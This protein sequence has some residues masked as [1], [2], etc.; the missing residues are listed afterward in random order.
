[1]EEY[2]YYP[3]LHNLYVVQKMSDNEIADIFNVS[4]KTIQYW[5]NKH[6]IDGIT[7]KERSRYNPATFYIDGEGYEQ[8]NNGTG[9]NE[10][11]GQSVRV[12]RLVA[13]AEHGIESVKNKSVHHKNGF[14][15]DN[16]PENLE[17]V[18]QSEHLTK[19]KESGDI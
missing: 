13:V 9:Q 12:H 14:K 11:G 3:I 17:I 6:D 7:D 10:D 5:R 1:M 15:R 16:R 19:H 18:S 8:W 2:R 4:R